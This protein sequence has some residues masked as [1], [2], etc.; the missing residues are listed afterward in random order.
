MTT[1]FMMNKFKLISLIYNNFFSEKDTPQKQRPMVTFSRREE[2]TKV[3]TN[4][5]CQSLNE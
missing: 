5:T 3:C 1:M 4:S 2:G